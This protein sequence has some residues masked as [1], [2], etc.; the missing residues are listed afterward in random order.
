MGSTCVETLT[1]DDQFLSAGVLKIFTNIR[2]FINK[3]VWEHGKSKNGKYFIETKHAHHKIRIYGKENYY[4]F[5]IILKLTGEKWY[6]YGKFIR[7]KNKNLYQAK[8]L[9]Y[10]TLKGLTSED[11]DEIK[12]LR[13][14]YKRIR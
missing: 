14:I 11:E 3:S 13:N 7:A 1:E 8:E 9:A 2:E 6:D 5:Q 10:I 12:L 4:S